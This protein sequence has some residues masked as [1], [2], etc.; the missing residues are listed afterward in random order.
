MSYQGK[1]KGDRRQTRS[2]ARRLADIDRAEQLIEWLM[3]NN[4]HVQASKKDIAYLLG[5]RY[6]YGWLNVD[7]SPDRRRVEDA[8]NLTRD[9]DDDPTVA[10]RLGGYVVSYAPSR[11]G[12]IL[13][14]PTGEMDL[15]QQV[16]M[17]DGDLQQQKK[18]GTILRRRVADWRA[19]RKQAA[20]AGHHDLAAVMSKIEDQIDRGAFV[21]TALIVE[22]ESLITAM[23]HA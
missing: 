17:L 21:E 1:S 8:C 16:H 3:D 6:G 13:I 4:G 19:A 5:Q 22:F 11:G 20:I 7:G 2:L 14:T 10:A 9:Q 23:E 15:A 18:I 12:L